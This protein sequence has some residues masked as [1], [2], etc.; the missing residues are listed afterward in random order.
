MNV[1]SIDPKA[2]PPSLIPT[3]KPTD[4]GHDELELIRVRLSAAA[5]RM[6]SAECWWLDLVAE[7]DETLAW[8]G[9]GVRDCAHWVA[10]SCSMSLGTAREHVRVARALRTLPLI[11]G[12]FAAGRLSY[13]K[14]REATRIAG[15][16]EEAT[17]LSLAQTLTASQ[18]ETSTRKFR[19]YDPDRV[20]QQKR[21]KARWFVDDDGM[22]VLTARLP[23]E[24][25]A[26]LIAALDSSAHQLSAQRAD[27]TP[28]TSSPSADST[29][30]PGAG[31]PFGIFD[32]CTVE[33]SAVRRAP[34]PS[35][36]CVDALLRVARGFLAGSPADPSGED[37]HLV[38]VHVDARLLAET[39]GLPVPES[40]APESV[41]PEPLSSPS[42]A[43]PAAER[44]R[45]ADEHEHLDVSAVPAEKCCEVARIGGV[46]PGTAARLACDA[47]VVAMVRGHAGAVLNYGRRRRLVSPHQRRALMVRDGSC[48][49]PSCARTTHLVAH[50]VQ[51]WAA[52]GTT[53]LGNLVL[54][55]QL[56]HMAVHEAGF[57]VAAAADSTKSVPRWQFTDPGGIVLE[58]GRF[59]VDQGD[60]SGF[61]TTFPLD[62]DLDEITR[63]TDR[64]SEAI[65]PRWAGEKVSIG[66][67]VD[68][69]LRNTLDSNPIDRQKAA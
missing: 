21:R 35:V 61:R 63:W 27:A 41:A 58:P 7:C 57:G 11:H 1:L 10:Y 5:G 34:D 48:Q 32:N 44:L 47:M 55:C 17:L 65:R 36:S 2:D 25:G 43:P 56:H 42:E 6:A 3:S 19:K 8:F 45:A 4:L 23:A 22:V 33:A 64:G 51:H 16:V 38:V 66:D 29:Q 18:F 24:E 37:R 14:V 52:G 28:G 62:R 20:E 12:E 30:P 69:L 59:R 40:V 39:V 53:D 26:E 60:G 46:A 13:S 68:V 9:Y 15:R 67:I 31:A 50:H 49:F 54:L